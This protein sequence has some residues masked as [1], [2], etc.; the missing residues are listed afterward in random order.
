MSLVEGDPSLI[1][2]LLASA[3]EEHDRA[4]ERRRKEAEEAEKKRLEEEKKEK[5]RRQKEQEQE[6]L[7]AGEAP[8]QARFHR[9]KVL[10]GVQN[11]VDDR[12]AVRT[13][14][15]FLRARLQDPESGELTDRC[16]AVLQDVHRCF[17]ELPADQIGFPAQ[18]Y[19]DSL[20][21]YGLA[22]DT[23]KAMEYEEFEQSC[24][25]LVAAD[26]VLLFRL[27]ESQG[28]DYWLQK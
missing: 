22:A 26:V 8:T 3:Q 12:D 21:E 11:L 5:I 27:L 28:Y 13:L 17:Q 7:N 15:E 4:E 20:T 19:E 2:V 10:Y 25:V 14:F 9:L 16:R 23:I 24:S 18:P 6:L 1:D